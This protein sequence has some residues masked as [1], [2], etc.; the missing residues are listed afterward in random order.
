MTLSYNRITPTQL[1]T[2]LLV[3]LACSHS[4]P[5]V[6]ECA[7]FFPT[8][9]SI[10]EATRHYLLTAKLFSAIKFWVEYV[11]TLLRLGYLPSQSL[12]LKYPIGF[13]SFDFI[14]MTTWYCAYTWFNRVFDVPYS[15]VKLD[16]WLP[17]SCRQSI[18]YRV[19][20]VTHLDIFRDAIYV[21]CGRLPLLPP[22]S[23]YLSWSLR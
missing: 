23:G 20:P 11:Y 21:S 18:N 13:N 5:P 10:A 19:F 9:A 17:T 4:A 22:S 16:C 1:E 15:I 12:R 2:S 8:G 6:N 3:F 14:P 7:R